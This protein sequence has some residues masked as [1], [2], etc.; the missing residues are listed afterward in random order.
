MNH[1]PTPWK[2]DLRA[3]I[4]VP[5]PCEIAASILTEDGETEIGHVFNKANTEFIVRA[6]NAHEDLQEAV[7]NLLYIHPGTPKYQDAV[8]FAHRALA[9]AE[10][11]S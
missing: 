5:D 2:A 6:C 3:I 9:K 1:T 4:P 10:V 11:K 8:D 7:R